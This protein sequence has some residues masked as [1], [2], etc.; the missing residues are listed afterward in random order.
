MMM[1]AILPMLVLTLAIATYA[2]GQTYV[3]GQTPAAA[4]LRQ[5]QL[6]TEQ[7]GMIQFQHQQNLMAAQP[8]LAGRQARM[9]IDQSDIR[10]EQQ[11]NLTAQM[12]LQQQERAQQQQ[13]LPAVQGAA[14]PP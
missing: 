13:A 12:Q 4:G 14:P 3:P 10:R 6:R 8:G 2:H 9:Q 5:E 11:D 7:Q 1:R